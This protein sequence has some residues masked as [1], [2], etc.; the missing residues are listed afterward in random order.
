MAGRMTKAQWQNAVRRK[1]LKTRG[2]G[3]SLTNVPTFS[4]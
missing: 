4:K 1:R 2:V 3:G